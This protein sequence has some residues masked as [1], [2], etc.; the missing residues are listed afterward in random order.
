MEQLLSSI[1]SHK[2]CEHD[3]LHPKLLN[4]SAPV[5]ALPVSRIINSTI[6]S[7]YNPVRWKMGQITSLFKKG[8]ELSKKNYGPITVLP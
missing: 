3:K 1:K 7:C 4:I 8:D 2:S 5:M 6:I